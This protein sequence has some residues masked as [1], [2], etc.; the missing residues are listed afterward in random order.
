MAENTSFS[1]NGY[2][3]A[4][5]KATLDGIELP[6]IK[7]FDFKVSREKM[8]NWGMGSNPISRT[9]KHRE[10]SGSIEITHGTKELLRSISPTGLLVD[11]PAGIFLLTLEREDG[12]KELISMGSFEFMTDG[13]SGSVGDEDLALSCDIIF[14]RYSESTI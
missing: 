13:L 8:N 11:I 1:I 10:P 2:S 5:C 12:G 6:G 9:R 7:S 4:D 14:G 3:Y